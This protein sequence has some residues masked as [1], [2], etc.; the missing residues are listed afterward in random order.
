MGGNMIIRAIIGIVL[1]GALS[2]GA[3]YAAIEYLGLKPAHHH[4]GALVDETEIEPED[5]DAGEP[6]EEEFEG[7]PPIPLPYDDG[8][9]ARW[10]AEVL[11]GTG[12]YEL[13]PTLGPAGVDLAALA[14]AAAAEQ[15]EAPAGPQA[16]DQVTVHTAY[17][18]TSHVMIGCYLERITTSWWDEGDGG[19]TRL[20]DEERYS[21]G[22]YEDEAGVWRV[23]PDTVEYSAR[24]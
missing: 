12:P 5:A 13:D 19:L 7:E 20:E 22:M 18:G 16:G 15:P 24:G 11:A 9:P 8:D 2:L 4:L 3:L 23:V 1:G 14:A 21:F 17:C 10:L 6:P